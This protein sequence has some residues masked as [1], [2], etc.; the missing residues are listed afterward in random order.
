MY[1]KGRRRDHLLIH[2]Q[3][4][5]G[6]FS[7]MQGRGPNIH[8]SE[9]ERFMVIV[10]QVTLYVFLIKDPITVKGE[11]TMTNKLRVASKIDLGL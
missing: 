6:H 5:F 9:D 1:E 7:N 2:L 3:C 4:D 10:S 11:L 8:R